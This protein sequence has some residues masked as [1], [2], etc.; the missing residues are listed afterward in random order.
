V[1]ELLT[2]RGCPHGGL[3][4][5]ACNTRLVMGLRRPPGSGEAKQSAGQMGLE[6]RSGVK[7]LLKSAC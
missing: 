7:P 4:L 3:L 2:A 5:L 6:E 1:P